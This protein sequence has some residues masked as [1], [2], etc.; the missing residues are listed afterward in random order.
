MGRNSKLEIRNSK[1]IRSSKFEIPKA[2][3]ETMDGYRV[4]FETLSLKPEWANE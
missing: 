2:A 1:E 3:L 4:K